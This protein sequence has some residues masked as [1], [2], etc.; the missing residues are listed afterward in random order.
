L[1]PKQQPD[2]ESALPQQS[3]DEVGV[4]FSLLSFFSSCCNVCAILRMTSYHI[5]ASVNKIV[6]LVDFSF[7]ST[8]SGTA[9]TQVVGGGFYFI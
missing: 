6:K 9:V 1:E 3:V 4:F 8:F 2:V 5:V 7:F